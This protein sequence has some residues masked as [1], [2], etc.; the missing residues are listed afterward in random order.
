MARFAHAFR[1][2]RYAERYGFAY[3]DSDCYKNA[4]AY[5]DCANTDAFAEPFT[6]AFD[7]RAVL[8]FDCN[9]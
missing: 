1:C 7:Y 6:S 3:A 2:E 5:S 9:P 4:N 8:H